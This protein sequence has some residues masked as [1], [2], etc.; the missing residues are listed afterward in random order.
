MPD[1]SALF[2]SPAARALDARASALAGDAGW[3]LMA[4]A[5]LAAWQYLLQH[6]PQAQHLCVVVGAGNNGGDGL[7]LARHALQAGRQLSVIGLADSRPTTALAQRAAR[8]LQDAGVPIEAFDGELPAADLLVDGL[9]GLG[10]RDAPRAGAQTLIDAINAHPAPVLALDVPSGVD[11]D[12]GSVPVRAVRAERTLQFI[13]AHRGLYTGAAL[14][15]AGE[16]ALAPLPVPAGAWEGVQPAAERWQGHRL[17]ALLPPRPANAHK[18]T[19]GHVLCVGGNH[20]SGGAL[21]LAAQAAL[22]SGAGL[23]SLATR[24]AHVGAAL[25]RLPEAMCHAVDCNADLQPL[26]QRASVIAVGPGLGQDEWAQAL[27]RDVRACG[28][29]LVVDADALNLLA[30]DPCALPQAVLTPHPG[31]A[32]RLLECSTADIQAD[33]FAAAAALADRFHAVVVLKGAGS[34]VAAPGYV[35]ALIAAGNP[36]MAVGGMG[37]LLTGVI[38]ALRAQA[39]PAFDAAAAGAL[40]HGLAG[41]AAARDGA[42]GLLPTDLLAPLRRLCNPELPH[43]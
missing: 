25:T 5:G 31:E 38:A 2:D 27:W 6:W 22:R 10:L 28:K 40:L 7:V 35:P 30:R 15:H 17:R 4:A 33:R 1:L 23:T 19:S 8:E 9:L 37:D 21:L 29:P 34:I 14:E 41:D 32:S 42:R 24:V 12:R 43:V 39:L 3:G 26:L 18:G 16:R 13:V 11:A 36:G 20:G